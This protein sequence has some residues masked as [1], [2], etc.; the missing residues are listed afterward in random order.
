MTSARYTL[1]L[2]AAVLLPNVWATAAFVLDPQDYYFRAWEYYG[3]VVYRTDAA[4]DEWRRPEAGDLSRRSVLRYQDRW[5][6][7]VTVDEYGFRS[8][9]LAAEHFRV[10]VT[11]DSMVFG[12]GLSDDETLP[13]RLAER[14][15]VPI[16]NG[17]RTKLG[18]L[19]AHPKLETLE[20]LIEFR[21]ESGLIDHFTPLEPVDF[22]PLRRPSGSLLGVVPP[23]R[24]LPAPRLLRFVERLARDA[25]TELRGADEEH[26]FTRFRHRPEDVPRILA[27]VERR[28]RELAERGVRYVLVVI[29]EKQTVYGRSAGLSIDDVTYGF[30]RELARRLRERGLPTADL[31]SPMI[32]RAEA[33]GPDDPLLYFRTDTHWT[34]A[35]VALAVD[36]VLAQLDFAELLDVPEGG[37]PSRER[38]AEGGRL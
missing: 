32:A 12:S 15:G 23:E 28:T 20:L 33:A 8:V 26:R 11:G 2:L 10:A 21:I 37:A 36:E 3:D 29:P 4:S 24:Y 38:V 27:D 16:Y 31:A 17:A 34:A 22:Q 7:T 13:W 5:P 1:L 18:N 25:G 35:G 19:L 30:A 9:P 14:L 6:T